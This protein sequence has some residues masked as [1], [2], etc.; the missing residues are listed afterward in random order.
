MLQKLSLDETFTP[1]ASD[2]RGTEIAHDQGTFKTIEPKNNQDLAAHGS[3]GKPLSRPGKFPR[4][5]GDHAAM[6]EKAASSA[7]T[8]S[9]GKGAGQMVA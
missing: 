6:S 1:Q 2:P 5:A 9:S 3:S 7:R 4:D 8:T